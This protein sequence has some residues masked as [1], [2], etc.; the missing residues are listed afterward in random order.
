MQEV[1]HMQHHQLLGTDGKVFTVNTFDRALSVADGQWGD[2]PQV[3]SWAQ[4]TPFIG[5]A[6]RQELDVTG[7]LRVFVIGPASDATGAYI[8]VTRVPVEHVTDHP[9]PVQV[10]KVFGLWL[11]HYGRERSED[12]WNGTNDALRAWSNEVVTMLMEAPHILRQAPKSRK[13]EQS[14]AAAEIR[15]TA[16]KQT[17]VA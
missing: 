15:G 11:D 9:C 10:A 2:A 4:G 17:Q 13:W 7:T 1:I 6:G 5:I 8:R 3:I 16:Y 14:F 12:A